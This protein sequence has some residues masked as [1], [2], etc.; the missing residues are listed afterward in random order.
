MALRKARNAVRLDVSRILPLVRD[1]VAI[2]DNAIAI[3]EIEG[4]CLGVAGSS[5]WRG[6]TEGLAKQHKRRRNPG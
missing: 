3:L 5:C 4:L 6:K 1:A 2:E